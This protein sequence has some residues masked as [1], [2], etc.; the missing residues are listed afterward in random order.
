VLE[1]P[2]HQGLQRLV[3]DLNR[4]YREHPA[5]WARDTDPEGFQWIDANDADNNVL[6]FVRWDVD[7]SQPVV[8]VCN[9]SPVPRTQRVGL[10]SRGDYVEILNT[11]AEVYGGGNVGNYGV[12]SAEDTPWHGQP[13]SAEVTAPPLGT[14]WLALREGER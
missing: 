2:D 1:E 14:L 8:C 6:S 5:L 9:F 13:A 10:P 11:D 7:G 4:I 12:V 3:S